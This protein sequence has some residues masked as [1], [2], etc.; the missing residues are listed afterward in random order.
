LRSEVLPPETTELADPSTTLRLQVDHL[1]D[2]IRDQEYG[3]AAN[4]ARLG[5]ALF[6]VRRN[7]YWDKW[8]YLSFGSYIRELADR[9]RK[10]RSQ[11]YAYI[12][13]AEKLLP[14]IAEDM[15]VAIGISK[16][17]ELR[18]FVAQSGRRLPQ[19][20]LTMAVD[21]KTTVKELRAAVFQELHQEPDPKSRYF[22]FGGSYY[23]TDEKAE[24]D[25]AIQI[26]KGTDP[27]IP[28]DIPHHLQMK[29]VVLRWA[30][31]FI[32]TWQEP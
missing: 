23:T 9:V 3:L 26:A 6:E 25:L 28:H 16:A 1:L 7:Q 2:E 8:G 27:V 29:E 31:E 20:L 21:D 30:R 5:A 13:T 14:Y 32:N 24:I 10:E 4:W 22:D 18:R 12:G 19:P 15:L 17:G 11:L